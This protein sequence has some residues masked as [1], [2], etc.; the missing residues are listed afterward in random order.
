M[1]WQ[2]GSVETERVTHRPTILIQLMIPPDGDG[3]SVVDTL[4]I[5]AHM[6]S[7]IPFAPVCLMSLGRDRVLRESG[8]RPA[9]L[10]ASRE[11]LEGL[12]TFSPHLAKWRIRITYLVI[13]VHDA[14]YKALHFHPT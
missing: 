5:L 9:T 2:V 13:Y 14:L 3:S 4:V 7:S 1:L 11:A 8:K 12:E 6:H 10:A